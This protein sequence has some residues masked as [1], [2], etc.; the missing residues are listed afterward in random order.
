LKAVK[1]NLIEKTGNELI[2]AEVIEANTFFDKLFGLITRRKLK[3]REGFLIENCNG[4]H[5]FWMRYN[6]DVVFLD[7]KKRVLTIYYSLKPFRTTPFVKNAFFV[8]ELKSGTIEKTSLKPG[9]LVS[10]EV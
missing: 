4:I 8:L 6:I 1:L 2:A 3:D 5:T 9:D 7:R 10:F